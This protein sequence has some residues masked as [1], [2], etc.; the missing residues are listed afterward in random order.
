MPHDPGVRASVVSLSGEAEVVGD[1]QTPAT[2][3][4]R[5]CRPAIWVCEW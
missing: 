1:E 5:V 4:R 2:G 3:E